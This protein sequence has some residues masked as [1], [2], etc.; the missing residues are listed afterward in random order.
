M[1][2]YTKQQCKKWNSN[3]TVN[4]ESERSIKTNGPTYKKLKAFCTDEVKESR[5]DD[6]RKHR[7]TNPKTGRRIKK[8]GDIYQ[9]YKHHCDEPFSSDSESEY[10]S[11]YSSDSFSDSESES[12]RRRKHRK[13]Y[14]I[15]KAGTNTTT[16]LASNLIKTY[17]EWSDKKDF[18]KERIN[19]EK[20]FKEVFAKLKLDNQKICMTGN[21]EFRKRL[22]KVEPIGTGTYGEVYY[23]MLPYK[24]IDGVQ[25]AF[26]FV[27]KEAFLTEG[28]LEEI[29]TV[30]GMTN[31]PIDKSP[32]EYFIADKIRQLIKTNKCHNFAYFY[33]WGLCG[34]CT[35][36]STI[37][38][39]SGAPASCSVLFM[40][41]A[42]YDLSRV[43]NDLT[44][45]DVW[46][47][48]YQ[49]LFAVQAMHAEYGI[50]HR[51]LRTQNILIQRLHPVGYFK[52]IINNNLTK[53]PETFYVKNTGYFVLVSDFGASYSFLST[54]A[55][56]MAGIHDCGCR[57]AELVR[58]SSNTLMF[59]PLIM[60]EM[61]DIKDNRNKPNT[62]KCMWQ[63]STG[64]TTQSTVNQIF[65]LNNKL[66]STAARDI[67]INDMVKYPP[68]NFFT[69][70]MD[71]LN[72]FIGGPRMIMEKKYVHKPFPK[73]PTDL[74]NKIKRLNIQEK[75]LPYS[76]YGTVKFIVAYKMVKHLQRTQDK[77]LNPT[78]IVLTC[79][80]K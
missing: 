71:V 44:P 68:F 43:I 76:Q 58:S 21:Q 67:D 18:F 10:D 35:P 74:V 22:T 29:Q 37:A 46:S 51:D 49:T 45:D 66:K 25:Y 38:R 24:Q 63:M 80:S 47:I 65:T 9:Y 73:A 59:R 6:W 23:G 41:P 27:A 31:I 15:S 75:K 50:L 54:M 40:E 26:K 16:P 7:L 64:R 69:D 79:T 30:T 62:H 19:N 60:N 14:I 4:P 57:N 13:K 3:K 48:L 56:P 32:H 34:Y 72:M 33:D 53:E 55:H 12:R 11:G 5:C 36:G 28:E 42:N 70:I 20:I 61:Y 17:T 8:S 39:E 77:L 1:A 52:Y 2:T 78:D